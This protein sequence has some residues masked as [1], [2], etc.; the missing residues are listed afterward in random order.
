MWNTQGLVNGASDKKIYKKVIETIARSCIAIFFRKR[1]SVVFR[2]YVLA[3]FLICVCQC[4]NFLP[5]LFSPSLC[6]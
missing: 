1:F 4:C 2:E 5:A 6:L 3:T